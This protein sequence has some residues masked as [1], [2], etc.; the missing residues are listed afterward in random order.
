MSF[1][2]RAV[3][4]YD[5]RYILTATYRFDGSSKFAAGNKWAQF[6]SLAF[7]WRL[8]QEKWFHIPAVSSA[9]LRLGWGMVGN[10]GIPS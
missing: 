2:A 3:Y 1:F 5:E 8:N 9:K 4:N 7:A 6:P 10:Q